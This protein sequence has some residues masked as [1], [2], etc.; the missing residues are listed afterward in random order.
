MMSKT[1]VYQNVSVSAFGDGFNSKEKASEK[2]YFAIAIEQEP[3]QVVAK[4]N[5]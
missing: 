2:G 5:G 4:E 1:W 3:S